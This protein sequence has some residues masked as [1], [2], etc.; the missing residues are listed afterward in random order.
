MALPAKDFVIEPAFNAKFRQGKAQD[1]ITEVLKTKLTNVTYHPDNTSTWTREIADD[2][3]GKLKEM[4]LERYKFVVQVV[5]GEQRGEGVKMG[6]RC[7]WDPNTD[8]YATAEFSN[9]SI[10]CVAAAYGVYLY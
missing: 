6:C 3:K 8:N 9:E 2:I 7:F 10:F 1:I 4:G 5:I